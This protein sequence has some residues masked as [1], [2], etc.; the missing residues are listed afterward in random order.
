MNAH[1][2]S[3]GQGS[4]THLPQVFEYA[5]AEAWVE[6]ML[7]EL[8]SFPLRSMSHDV[9]AREAAAAELNSSLPADGQISHSSSRPDEKNYQYS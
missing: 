2:E 4:C 3:A 1:H 6:I 8:A 9:F 5:P 7:A